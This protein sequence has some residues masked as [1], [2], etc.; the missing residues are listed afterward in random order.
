MILFSTLATLAAVALGLALNASRAQVRGLAK[1]INK[2]ANLCYK[3]ETQLLDYRAE[4][5]AEK[6]KA[7]TWEH[8]GLIAERDLRASLDQLFIYT[9]KA[10]KEREQNRI[11]KQKSRARKKEA[12]KNVQ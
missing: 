10:A 5:A 7:K 11:N 1:E 8:R 12:A 6:D 4:V 2:K 3:Y 9:E